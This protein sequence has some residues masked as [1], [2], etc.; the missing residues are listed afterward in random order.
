MEDLNAVLDA[1]YQNTVGVKPPSVDS[2]L[3]SAFNTV[4]SPDYK[5]TPDRPDQPPAPPAEPTLMDKTKEFIG[6]EVRAAGE[7]I[8]RILDQSYGKITAR[9]GTQFVFD[10]MTRGPQGAIE[11]QPEVATDI[12][13]GLAVGAAGFEKM[14]TFG[15]YDPFTQQFGIPFT[16]IK[17][18]PVSTP[19]P[20][21]LEQLGVSRE[22][23]NSQIIGSAGQIV[24]GIAGWGAVAKAIDLIAPVSFLRF[25]A[26]SKLAKSAISIGKETAT[27]AI[28]GG[29]QVREPAELA[30]L[31]SREE[32]LARP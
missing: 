11:A 4:S 8:S 23:A 5:F 7:S 25:G 32:L 15:A 12:A 2:A 31:P 14:A 26:G 18:K 9:N 3:D 28:V 19:L 22:V 13:G 17:S 29:A 20:E 24:G 6:K 27:G 10:W 30:P 1:A 16:S 21:A